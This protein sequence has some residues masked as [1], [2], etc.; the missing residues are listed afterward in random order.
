MT[1]KRL[2][3]GRLQIEDKRGVKKKIFYLKGD[4]VTIHDA[5]HAGPSLGKL[6]AL[7]GLP[8]KR[9][10]NL[11]EKMM[12]KGLLLKTDEYYL[13]LALRPREELIQNLRGTP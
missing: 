11:C 4:E 2:K 9:V 10:L 6:V 3:D 12:K 1:V 8:E 7:T 5:G 13:S